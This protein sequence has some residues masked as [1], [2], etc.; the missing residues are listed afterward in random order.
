MNEMTTNFKMKSPLN[1]MMIMMM[2]INRLMM[3]CQKSVQMWLL[4]ILIKR[5][6]TF[7]LYKKI[8]NKYNSNS[9]SSNSQL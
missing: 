6:I 4:K 8:V 7:N 9:N 1:L 2:N 3:S 5:T